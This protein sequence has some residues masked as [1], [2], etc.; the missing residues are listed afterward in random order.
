MAALDIGSSKGNNTVIIFI[1]EQKRL[2]PEE[3]S[4]LPDL[5]QQRSSLLLYSLTPSFKSPIDKY[6]SAPAKC[7]RAY[8]APVG[9]GQNVTKDNTETHPGLLPSLQRRNHIRRLLFCFWTNQLGVNTSRRQ[10]D[11]RSC[12][13]ILM[14]YN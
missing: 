2:L 12:L 7:Y 4:G 6:E 10:H 13:H 9:H 8:E 3:K 5:K 14:K 11:M 1:C